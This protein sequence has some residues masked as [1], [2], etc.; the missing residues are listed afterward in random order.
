MARLQVSTLAELYR[1]AA[2]AYENRP[3][4]AS[5]NA[6]GQYRPTS[7]RSLYEQGLALATALIDLGVQPREHVG[8]LA[9]NRLE[10]I[11]CDAG[12]QLAGC[13]DVPRGTDITEGEIA[14]ILDHAD[15]RVTFVENL[16]TLEKLGRVQGQLN[17]LETII[18]MDPKAAARDGVL[19][20]Q[21]LLARGAELRA[22]G[23]RRAEDR[24][25]AIQPEDLFTII[26]TSGT[27]GT[28][29]GV[30][31]THANMAS[32]VRNLPF[33]LVPG[34]RTLSILPIWH[35]YERVF[36]M[37]AISMGACTYYTSIR[38]IAEDLKTVKPNVMCSAPRL[39]ENLYQKLM[40]RV[41]E[42]APFKR[43]LFHMAQ[44]STCAVKR[45]ERFFRGQQ[46]DL[47]G[48]ST[49][50]NLHLG[51][52]HAANWLL[53]YLPH[54][55]LDKV[56]LSKIREAV[57]CSEFRGTIS[58]G[59]ALQPHVD[60]F[61]NFIGIPVLEGYGLTESSPV[62]A[63]RTWDNLVIGTVGPLYPQTEIR[64]VDLN[65]G[66]ILYPN[67]SRRG[68][69]RGLRGEIHVK[70]PQVMKGYYKNPAGT[71]SVLHDGWLNTGDIGMITFN[72]CLKILGRSK[73]TI[74][75]LSG[76]NVEPV[77][78]E[79]RLVH[80]PLIDNCM[81]VGQDQK[82][83]AALIVPSLLGFRSSGIQTSSLE[84]IA[85][86]PEARDLM[87]QELRGLISKATGFKNF[88]RIT[89]FRFVTRPFEV[90]R[91]LTGTYKLK[92]HIITEMYGDLIKDLYPE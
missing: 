45:A 65:T 51:I 85:K 36:E 60:E 3:A 77:P 72:D 8:L 34:E 22:A 38:S 52:S 39:W 89:D 92:R 55:I 47:T 90:G 25:A 61:F 83:L 41:E 7:Y 24:S 62:L 48:R 11:I 81:V 37:V 49:K 63:V 67:K 19:R 73:D 12:V 69:G 74:V 56:V 75:L 21:D 18:L 88:E 23:D 20:L 86:D 1:N 58:G 66:D 43:R 5:K 13:A 10:W 9:D 31:L 17:Q 30:Q 26:Y 6:E 14:Y 68:H 70:G 44:H 46:L 76:E 42:G 59:G 79:C 4:F 29:K 57:G 91:E 27:T 35:S 40:H 80:S 71:A 32:Q 54:R 84:E 53:Y 15:I 28:P 16:A 87:D 82:A 78:I 33:D 2:E 50:E 64:I